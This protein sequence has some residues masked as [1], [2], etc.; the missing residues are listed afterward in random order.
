MT[1]SKDLFLA[2]L[3]MDAYNRG[4]GAGLTVEGSDAIGTQIGDA[5]II[6][7]SSSDEKSDAFKAG[8]YAVAHKTTENIGTTETSGVI[9]KGT[10]LIAA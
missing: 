5:T 3:S 2:L 8:F 1:I 6:G 4:Y 10:T 7:R 9:P